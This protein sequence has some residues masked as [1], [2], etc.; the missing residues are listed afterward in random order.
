[1]T[2]SNSTL[3]SSGLK[4]CENSVLA[5]FPCAV[6]VFLKAHRSYHALPV[7]YLY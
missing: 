5:G 7:I 3:L 4:K 6:A 2:P 1:M